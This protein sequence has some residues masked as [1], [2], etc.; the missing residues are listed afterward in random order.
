[1]SGNEIATLIS[2][3][4]FPIAACIGLFVLIRKE[5][6]HIK[7]TVDNN[8]R[9]MREMLDLIQRKWGDNGKE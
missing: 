3:T 5:L 4:G 6:A 7:E 8:T 2:S 1:M 9:V